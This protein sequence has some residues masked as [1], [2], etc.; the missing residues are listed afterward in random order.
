MN[1]ELERLNAR[2]HLTEAV[3]EYCRV[4]FNDDDKDYNERFVAGVM[5]FLH[6]NYYEKP[7]MPVVGVEEYSEKKWWQFWK[8]S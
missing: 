3:L 2:N 7:Y 6:T 8:V 4:F 1:K 5:A